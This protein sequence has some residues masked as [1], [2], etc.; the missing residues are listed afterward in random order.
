MKKIIFFALGCILL[1]TVGCKKYL[2]EVNQDPNQFATA[3]PAAIL[4][5]SFKATTDFLANDNMSRWWDLG[6][7]IW[8]G[9]RFDLT[10][11]DVWKPMYVSVLSGITQLKLKYEN[12]SNYTNQVQIARIWESYAYYLLV[13]N[14][15]PVAKSQ[16]NNPDFQDHI[17]YD[18][19]NDVYNEILDTL[20]DAVSKIDVNKVNDKLTYD[21]IYGGDL[22]KWIKFGNTLRLEIALN[23]RRNLGS[24]AD[25]H[26]K[27]V[28]AND[29][30]TINSESETAKLKY[31]DVTNNQNPYYIKYKLN[32]QNTVPVMSDFL[33]LYLRS[34]H[35]PRLDAYFD[36]VPVRNRYEVTDTLLSSV[37]DSIRIVNYTVPHFGK[38][39]APTL[40]SGWTSLAGIANP[41]S[42]SSDT[43]YSHLKGFSYGRL[44]VPDNSLIA[45]D[46]PFMIL[47]YAQAEFL[48]AE[49]AELGLGGSESAEQYYEKGIAANFSFWGLNAQQLADYLNV[50]GIKWNTEGK[51]FY[52]YLGIVKADI[53]KDNLYKIWIQSWMN[54]FPDQAFEAW[55]LQRRT[56]ALEF[57]PMT[58]PGGGTVFTAYMDIPDRTPYPKSNASLNPTGYA[59]AL[60]KLGI[61]GSADDWNPY[62]PLKFM[63]P[64]TVKDWNA[65]VPHY[66]MSYVLKWYGNTIESLD[67]AGVP[68]KVLATFGAGGSSNGTLPRTGWTAWAN[69]G[70]N[71]VSKA[72]DGNIASRWS[73]SGPQN[74]GQFLAIDMQASYAI[75]TVI[76]D[77]GSSAGDF[78]A[79]YAVYVSN[80]KNNFGA[81]VATGIGTRDKT[82][83]NFPTVE[84]RYVKIEQ[85]GVK[86][87]YW[88]V[89]EVYAVGTIKL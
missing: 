71:D 59:D 57:P 50:D 63:P 78:P 25:A 43:T 74:P 49:A 16:A 51:G 64:F 22:N 2:T 67:S 32:N 29:A 9:Q 61:G 62:I 65:V 18:T 60:E 48:K 15:G 44:D 81:P 23:C 86:G 75:H 8:N 79:G 84:G 73:S 11:D 77:Q 46:R 21:V 36:S 88:S 12:D 52:N 54:F 34:Y 27:D 20:K 70:V 13:A 14:Y 85:T 35:D 37:D 58:N 72:L 80:D 1:I 33:F 31:E 4:Q 24:V 55:T 39:E 56:R 28:M 6:H 47:S 41:M 66:D 5:G 7:M 26:I 3:S 53:P 42:V 69:V 45:A 10:G 89:H 40:L 68:Y 38:P 17:L 83:I 19:E 30:N 82:E 76:L 87:N